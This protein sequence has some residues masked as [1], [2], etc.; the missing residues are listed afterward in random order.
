MRLVQPPQMGAA[1][2]QRLLRMRHS[3]HANG[4]RFRIAGRLGPGAVESSP[5]EPFGRGRLDNVSAMDG[6]ISECVI[7]RRSDGRKTAGDQ[8]EVHRQIRGAPLTSPGTGAEA[9]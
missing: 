9:T 6:I 7:E 3:S 5:S 1:P 4:A 2:S 8:L